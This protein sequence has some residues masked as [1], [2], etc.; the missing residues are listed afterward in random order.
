MDS[1]SSDAANR[2][3]FSEESRK[4]QGDVVMEN[5][6]EEAQSVAD[7]C[8]ERLHQ[9]IN[10][11]SLDFGAWNS[12][13]TEIEKIHPDDIDM[14]SLAYDSLLSK[15]PLCHWYWQR[16]AYHKARL[17]NADKAVETFEQAVELTPFSVGL[18]YEYC[19]FAITYSDDPDDVRRLFR[20]GLAIVGKDYY[21]HVLWDKYMVFEFSQ[22]KWVVL[23]KVYAQ[24]LRFPT[25]KL[26][27]YYKIFKDLV[28][29]LEEEIR[30][31]NDGNL[32]V[33]AEEL[34]NGAS[35]LSDKE[36]SQVVNDLWDPCDISV[37]CKALHRYKFIGDQLYQKA[38]QLD[39]KIKSFESNIQRRYFHI[40]PIDDDQ[41]N[42]WHRYLDFIEKQED[43]DWALKLYERCLISCANYPEFWMRYV[44]FMEAQGGRELALFAIERAK[45]V[46]LNNV[47]GIHLFSARFK[48]EIRDL[49]G[50]R[51]SFSNY[52]SGCDIYFIESVVKQ[53][54]MEKRLGNDEAACEI[55]EKALRWA[56][57]DKEKQHFLPKLYIHY[58]RLKHMLTGGAD[59]SRDVLIE[60]IKQ[61]PDSR[62]L[63]EELIRHAMMHDGAKQLSIMDSI[64]TTAISPLSDGSQGLDIKDRE[65]ISTLF[66]EF[67]DLC[68]TVH[69]V[70]KA[71]NLHIKL[72][73]Q[74]IRVNPLYKYPTSKE[75][76]SNSSVPFNL[77]SKNQ[78]SGDLIRQPEQEKLPSLPLVD[79]KQPSNVSAEQIPTLDDDDV[80]NK[81][82]QQ[83]SPKVSVDFDD[84]SKTD[85]SK[86]MELVDGLDP[87]PK[88]DCPQQMDWTSI[89]ERQ[90]KEDASRLPEQEQPSGPNVPPE[91]SEEEARSTNILC[92][93]ELELEKQLESVSLEKISPDSQQVP[94]GQVLVAS[95]HHGSEE[96][97]STSSGSSEFTHPIQTQNGQGDPELPLVSEKSGQGNIQPRESAA[98]E[99][100]SVKHGSENQ[101]QMFSSP[102]SSAQGNTVENTMQTS[103]QVGHAHQGQAYDQMWQY[104][105]Q[106]QYELLQQQ[107]QQYQQQFL[108]MQQSY[109][110]QQP[111]FNQQT[112]QQQ[113]PIF[114]QLQSLPYQQQ[115][116]YQQQMQQQYHNQQYQQMVQSM[117]PYNQS[118]ALAYQYQM[119]QQGY[120][121]VLQQYQLN[122]QISHSLQQ[123][124]EQGGYPQV[125]QHQEQHQHLQEQLDQGQQ[126]VQHGTTSLESQPERVSTQSKTAEEGS[127]HPKSAQGSL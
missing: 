105:S 44:D 117:Q 104:H 41:L 26:Q 32:E 24:A 39:E 89:S 28:I 76:Q 106:Q 1:Q 38:C 43:F 23:A 75:R 56:M 61:V 9:L 11:D 121:Q 100:I 35:A 62:L 103:Q 113:V 83:L 82:L 46:F 69:D 110:H 92:P 111:Y 12:L 81:K 59:T 40:T 112:Y 114:Q 84:E 124:Q 68:G 25:Q 70:K 98:Q 48:E 115:I 87:R 78:S 74:L 34:Y 63:Y 126:I 7:S 67:V 52:D 122:Q 49:G 88:E 120:E 20:K 51:A 71:W 118:P 123:Q 33:Q 8:H 13:I 86:Q 125:Q 97:P 119:N 15:F 42:N 90:S 50:A 22:Q 54:N 72:F 18:W 91:T 57:P 16:Y 2:P 66:L 95:N 45:T 5:A 107:Y 94:E 58:Y 116:Q 19:H 37:R 4:V 36:I 101:P 30:S 64:I 17:C 14:I 6:L 96:I 108:Q 27:K 80:A 53:A 79:D 77:S 93:Q 31:L 10:G 102:V 99:D 73:P 47:P 109:P 85:A 21:C 65:Y 60:G 55:Y 127:R 3:Q 29:I